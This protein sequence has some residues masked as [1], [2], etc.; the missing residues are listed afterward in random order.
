LV[1]MLQTQRRLAKVMGSAQR[2]QHAVAADELVQIATVDVFQDEEVQFVFAVDIVGT[3][4][5]GMVEPR[6][7]AGL[8]I[9][10]RQAGGIG[11]LGWKVAAVAASRSPLR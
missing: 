8:T 6:R 11:C 4:D 2:G 10:A 7:R 5:V 9:E 3:D 1:R